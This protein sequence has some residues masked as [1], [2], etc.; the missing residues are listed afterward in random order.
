[1]DVSIPHNIIRLPFRETNVQ[2]ALGDETLEEFI[3]DA[4]LDRV[5]AYSVAYH[6]V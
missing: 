2:N 3:I 1:M 5:L 4:R 6:D